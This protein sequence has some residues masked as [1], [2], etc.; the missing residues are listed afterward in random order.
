MKYRETKSLP[1]TIKMNSISAFHHKI[2]RCLCSAAGWHASKFSYHLNSTATW[3]ISKKRLNNIT[4]PLL[5]PLP[6]QWSSC[7]LH[8]HNNKNRTLFSYPLRKTFEF[9]RPTRNSSNYSCV[10]IPFD[11]SQCF[12]HSGWTSIRSS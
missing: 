8:P 9:R 6:V 2:S 12:Q 4:T 1:K 3:I 10:R 5:I 7:H 11:V